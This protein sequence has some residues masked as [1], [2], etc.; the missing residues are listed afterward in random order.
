MSQSFHQGIYSFSNGYERSPTTTKQGMEWIS[1]RVQNFELQQQQQVQT[2]VNSGEPPVYDDTGG[3]MLTEMIDFSRGRGKSANHL[4]L[5][6][7]IPSSYRWSQKQQ[8]PLTVVNEAELLLMNP[9]HVKASSSSP[10]STSSLHMSVPNSSD[11]H[12]PSLHLQ[13]YHLENPSQFSWVRVNGNEVDDDNTK[14]GR[15][16]EAQGLSLSLSSSMPNL[17]AA[18]FQELRPGDGGVYFFDQGVG[19][20][21]NFSGFKNQEPNPNILGNIVTDYSSQVHVGLPASSRIGNVLRNPRYLRAAQELLEEFCCVGKGN[22]KSPKS[23]NPRTISIVE[24]ASGGAVSSASSK[25]RPPLSAAEKTEYQ[26]KKVKL[27][28]MLDEVDARYT[29]YCEQMQAIVHSFDSVIGYGAAAPYTNLAQKAMSRHFRSIKEAILGQVKVTCE[30]LGDKDV[31][32]TIGLT[33]GETPRLRLLEQKFRQQKALHQLG[34]LDP[35]TWRPQRGLPER[36]VNILRAWLFE[37]FLHP[38]PS[39]ADKHLL[40]RQTGLSKNQVSNWFI[41][42][43][44]R[45]WKPMVEDIY[46]EETKDEEQKKVTTVNHHAAN[47]LAKS[48]DS[49]DEEDHHNQNQNQNQNHNI[50]SAQTPMT[51]SKTTT[52]TT[53]L[54]SSITTMTLVD[55]RRSEI[56][57]VEKDPSKNTINNGQYTL[58]NQAILQGTPSTTTP[59]SLI[60]SP[61]F[62]HHHGQTLPTY[63]CFMAIPDEAHVGM[64]GNATSRATNNI[65]TTGSLVGMGS[66]S[67]AGD[68]SLTLGLRH[69][70]SNLPRKRTEFS[71][72]DFGAF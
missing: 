62:G 16:M 59:T 71:L 27:L 52:A 69:P 50:V 39:D 43:R 23:E 18:K 1:Q 60:S 8:L 35:E 25:D 11:S 7:Q 47:E 21:M 22:L 29:H 6:G 70:S 37:H 49:V 28:S 44:V 2:E 4:L 61:T 20:P 33:K 30:L 32:G 10:T 41:N 24:N 40:S 31:N 66:T 5:D 13:E 46:K 48:V 12:H 26:R 72:R 68:V 9:L 65:N 58:G 34:M 64:H 36:S 54:S 53:I 3:G 57:A 45:L 55:G 63:G 67:Q 42:A 14:I 17:E 38:Y 19:P 51:N 15:A 56:N